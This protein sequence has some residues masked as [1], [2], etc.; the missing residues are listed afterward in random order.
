MQRKTPKHLEDIRQAAGAIR[1]FTAGRT[2]EDYRSDG[3]LRSAVERNFEIIGE[4]MNRI[5]K[6]DPETAVDIGDHARIIA[7]RN[8][9]VHGYDLIDDQQVWKVVQEQLPT[10]QQQVETLLR[11]VDDVP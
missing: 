5:A 7:F 10:L 2:L 9:L 11:E 6:Q 4:A 1:Q 3:M 8:I